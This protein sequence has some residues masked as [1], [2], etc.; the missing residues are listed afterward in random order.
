MDYTEIKNKSERELHDLLQKE[1][2]TL[3][4]LRFKSHDGQL[5]KVRS[6]REAR[7]NIARIL[8]AVKVAQRNHSA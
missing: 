8:T 3:R 1:R 2:I 4:T 5:K 7:Q 6:I